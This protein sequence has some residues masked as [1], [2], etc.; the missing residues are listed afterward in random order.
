MTAEIQFPKTL[1]QAI[2]HF[3][4]EDV[5]FDFMKQLR[6]P[7][8]EVTCPRCGSNKNSF[9]STRK[10]WTCKECTT[11]KQFTIRVG[12]ILED[13][14]IPFDKWIC[15]FWLLANAKNGISS[16]ELGK[17]IGVM[18]RTGWFMLQRIRLALQNG[19][20]A[21]M[22]GTC[23][24][25]ET[26]IGAKARY[27]HKHRRTGVGDAGIKKT[28]IQGILERTKGQKASRVVLKVVGTTRRPELCGNVRQ[29]VLAGST[30]CTDALM[31]YDDLSKD[32]DR[33]IIDHLVSYARGTVH[34]N[35]LENFWSLLKR[36]LK[37][38]YVNVEPFHL[39]RYCDEQAFRFNER[40]D[41][42]G[43]QGRFLKAMRGMIGK[44]LTY[45]NLTGK[46]AM[47]GALPA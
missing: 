34:T 36:S 3:A 21:K 24:A 8:G 32:Y 38:T 20:I 4:N 41:K 30:V 10:L 31:S 39:F 19:S 11:K 43:D 9:I 22:K 42:N 27:M 12:T 18:Q 28:P 25:D 15:A 37:G 29:Y 46:D 2:K 33:Q 1:Q 26:Y 40:K 23:E 44:R 35:G 5:A 13:S 16:Y 7:N 47:A 45:A 17:A 14:P 6:W